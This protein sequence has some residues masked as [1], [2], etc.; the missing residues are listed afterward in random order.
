MEEKMPGLE[1]YQLGT[2]YLKE[3]NYK[4][5]V[6]YFRKALLFYQENPNQTPGTLL[7]SYG[8][9]TA[10]GENQIKEGVA[11]CKKG[12]QRKDQAPE[13]YLYLAELCLI[14]RRKAEAYQALQ[15]G[16]KNF[17]NNPRLI[18]KIKEFGVRKKPL[19]SILKRSH[20]VNKVLGKI[21]REPIS[22]K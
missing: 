18:E 8:Y 13:Q 12:I 22:K 7:S 11:F 14:N 16:L 6:H 19:L 2:A 17:R 21:L 10:M 5:A 15:A 4:E 20:P 1:E 9:A 3:K